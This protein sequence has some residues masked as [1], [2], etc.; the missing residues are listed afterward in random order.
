[1]SVVERIPASCAAQRDFAVRPIADVE[2][3]DEQPI[4]IITNVDVYDGFDTFTEDTDVMIQGNHIIEVNS[5]L[6]RRGATTIDGGG[7][8]LTPGLIDMHT[9]VTFNS[10]EENNTFGTWDFGAVFTPRVV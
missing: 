4:T 10:P 7:R 8:T 2:S 1:M 5:N 6:R 9:R 3:Q